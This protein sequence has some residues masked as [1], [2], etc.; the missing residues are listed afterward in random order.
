[1]NFLF[2]HG[3]PSVVFICGHINYEGDRDFFPS[4][5]SSPHF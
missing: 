5:F 2:H 3:L 1:M 4:F